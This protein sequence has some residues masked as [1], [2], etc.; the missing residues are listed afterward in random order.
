M[1]GAA[2]ATTQASATVHEAA[3]R[4]SD[5][6]V[7][8]SDDLAAT[9]AAVEELTASFTEI[10]HQVT[11]AADVSR[12]AVRLA[13]ASQTTI[14][15]LAEST[16][17]IGDIVKMI[18]T[19]A[20]QTNLLA[21]NATIEAARAGDAGKGFAVV[22]GEV[23]ALAA[24]TA[25]ATAEIGGQIATAR[26]VTEAT[27]T[28]MT[29][30]GSMIGRMDEISSTMAAAVEEQSV[31]AREIATKVTAVSGA[32]AHSTQAMGEVVLVARQAGSTSREL[33][34]DAAGIDQE[35][36]VL[37]AQVERFL[38]TVRTDSGERRR[39]E[40]FGVN[41][42]SA[43]VRLAGQGLI[44]VT[45]TDLSEGGAALRCD[46][47]IAVGSDLAFELVEGGA[48]VPANVVRA[49]SGGVAGIAFPDDETVRLQIRRF[50]E[51]NL[52]MGSQRRG[53]GSAQGGA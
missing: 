47:P 23:K 10:T 8:S 52:S 11:K 13:D 20:S 29:E 45:I 19:I 34:S 50:L 43:R 16:G 17:R 36:G 48:T 49:E 4:T 32:T 6:A 3:T 33:L 15:R 18:E 44:R 35:A 42:V 5:D 14:R 40:R 30:I 21:L 39:F 37:R 51:Q 12:Q 41:G 26:S 2:E 28:A 46:Q 22:A 9:A 24:E 7:K 1:R 31:T 27:I 53:R 25:R 38:V